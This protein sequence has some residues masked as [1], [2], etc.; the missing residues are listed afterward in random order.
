L[1]LYYDL[2]SL[3]ENADYEEAKL[4]WEQDLNDIRIDPEVIEAQINA[5]NNDV[6]MFFASKI[7]E[8]VRDAITTDG[9][10]KVY[11]PITGIPPLNHISI[12]NV[13]KHLES[14]WIEDTGVDK[15][16]EKDTR[17]YVLGGAIIATIE[18]EDETRIDHIIDNLR[19]KHSSI[20]LTIETFRRIRSTILDDVTRLNKEIN[21]RIIN[22]ISK[23]LYKTT[24]SK[25]D[26]NV[27][28]GG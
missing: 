2:S 24:C 19:S 3:K 11:E 21:K 27:L 20:Y 9:K 12:H 7:R 22:P 5:L 18:P 1:K 6:D 23:R 14:D 8:L 15:R 4:H 25:C 10:L 13:I 28:A 16:Y 26:D 17:H